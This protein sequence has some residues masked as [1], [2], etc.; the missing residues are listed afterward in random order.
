MRYFSYGSNMCQENMDKF[1]NDRKRPCIDISTRNP[2]PAILKNH[3]LAFNVWAPSIQGGAGNIEPSAGDQVEGTVF[4]LT[5]DDMITID[6]K[7]GI[8]NYEIGK[9]DRYRR[10]T[11]DLTLRDGN[12]LTDVITYT[13]NDNTKVPDFCPPT[14]GYKKDVVDGARAMGL[15][16]SWVKMLEDLPT[17][18]H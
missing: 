16:E 7:E 12:V 9:P 2:R 8:P 18:D 1:C 3:R 13:A 5:D 6:M 4:D 17:Q 11:V 14:K 15:S 10:I